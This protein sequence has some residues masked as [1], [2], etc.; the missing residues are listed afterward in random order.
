MSAIYVVPWLVDS[1]HVVDDVPRSPPD[2]GE[3]LI[4]RY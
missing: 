4:H 3:A 1:S 2:I